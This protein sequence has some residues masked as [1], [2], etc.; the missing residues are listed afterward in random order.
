M[1][2][3]R[4]VACSAGTRVS[5]AST[6]GSPGRA[7]T[8]RAREAHE[9]SPRT[10]LRDAASRAEGR[11]HEVIAACGSGAAAMRSPPQ[12]GE[13]LPVPLFPG[14]VAMAQID[15]A[16]RRGSENRAE[17]RDCGKKCSTRAPRCATFSSDAPRCGVPR[18]TDRPHQVVPR[19]TRRH[20]VVG[21]RAHHQPAHRVP[22][23]RDVG[24]TG[25][26]LGRSAGRPA[27]SACRSR[28]R[29]GRCCSASSAGSSSCLH[30]AA[31]RTSTRP[32]RTVAATTRRSRRA[33]AGTR[34]C[35]LSSRV[36]RA[37][38][39]VVDVDVASSGT[40]RHRDGRGSATASSSAPTSPLTAATT[41]RPVKVASVGAPTPRLASARRPGWRRARRRRRRRRGHR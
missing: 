40:E 23:E 35:G 22:D 29:A 32:G 4:E 6:T 28:T 10:L 27:T 1:V 3:Q 37:E 38:A 15:D 19:L 17:R 31:G 18:Q 20:R 41:C 36:R 11:D 26:P 5:A 14:D 39:G 9:Q 2:E 7:D 33:R 24:D 16:G 21:R 13:V 12:G 8:G 30:A 34:R 25:R